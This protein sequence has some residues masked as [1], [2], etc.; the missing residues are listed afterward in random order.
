M[1][2]KYHP[3]VAIDKKSAEEKFKQISEA[4]E[5]LGDHQKRANYDQ[6]GTPLANFDWNDFTRAQDLVDVWNEM[7]MRWLILNKTSP[8]N[9]P[10]QQ[11]EPLKKG[12]CPDCDGT[13]QKRI[14][15]SYTSGN[16]QYISIHI[17]P[18]DKC[19]GSG[20]T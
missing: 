9:F 10:W 13:G 4:Y 7:Q 8:F 18:C 15:Q 6:S 1:V 3:D 17:R 5:V 19:G 12:N 20:N 2:K 14:N 11:R 16:N